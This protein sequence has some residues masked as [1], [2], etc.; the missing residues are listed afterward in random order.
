MSALLFSLNIKLGRE[1]VKLPVL[2][3]D[4]MGQVISRLAEVAAVPLERRDG[5]GPKLNQQLRHLLAEGKLSEKV[6]RKVMSLLG[7]EE[8]RQRS[9]EAHFRILRES[10]DRAKLNGQMEHKKHFKYLQEGPNLNVNHPSGDVKAV[11]DHH[12]STT[13]P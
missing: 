11:L 3:N 7:K 5:I 10:L 2:A 8:E 12:Q 13:Q 4:S 6:K 9:P 1:V